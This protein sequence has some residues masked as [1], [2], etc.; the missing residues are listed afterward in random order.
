M[1]K[2]FWALSFLVCTS[3]DLYSQ[4][5]VGASAG[6]SF[7][8]NDLSD[9]NGEDFNIDENAFGY[10]IYA[11]YGIRFLGIEGGYRDLGEVKSES[12]QVALKSK[13]NGWDV[14]LR[15]KLGIGPIIAFAKA[16]SFFAK[17]ENEAGPR[18]YSENT[19]NF[20]WGLGA[21][22]E[23]GRIGVRAEYEGMGNSDSNLGM[24]TAGV[25][26]QLGGKEK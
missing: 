15:G 21:G 8:N 23:F 17:Y 1:K 3:S 11:G 13:I 19:T 18:S 24:L 5:Y 7:I 26:V 25:T 9:I 14:A 16:G 4:L 22:L 12:G 2:L 20:L 10:K 6:N